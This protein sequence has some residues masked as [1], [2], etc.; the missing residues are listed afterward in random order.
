VA[1]VVSCWKPQFARQ[2]GDRLGAAV[3]RLRGLARRPPVTGWGEAAVRF[4][5]Q[6]TALLARRWPALTVTTAVNHP[7][8]INRPPPCRPSRR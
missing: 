4:R 7:A 5:G 8:G 2:V 6:S 1:S 3:T